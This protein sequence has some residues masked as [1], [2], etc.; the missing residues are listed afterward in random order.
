MY[1]Y[2]LPSDTHTH[3][4]ERGGAASLSGVVI[5]VLLIYLLKTAFLPWSV[6]VLAG[7]EYVHFP[8]LLYETHL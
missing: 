7:I 4:R 6:E 3:T 1:S 8:G 2:K 5:T